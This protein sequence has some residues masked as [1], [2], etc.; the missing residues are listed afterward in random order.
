MK[1][2]LRKVGNSRGVLIPKAIVDLLGITDTLE[3]TVEN[4]AVLLRPPPAVD[5]AQDALDAQR[6]RKLCALL[7]QGYEDGNTVEGDGLTLYCGMKS[8]WK[9]ERT[10]GA[11]ITWRDERDEPLNLAAALD[12]MPDVSREAG[13]RTISAA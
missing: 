6:F 12:R 7:R 13:S 11:E 2:T 3:L 4:G 10:V 8:G 1:T 9:S 5:P